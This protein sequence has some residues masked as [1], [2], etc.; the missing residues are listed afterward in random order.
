MDT[1]MARLLSAFARRVEERC[2]P[3]AGDIEF[4]EISRGN[5]LNKL[6]KLERMRLLGLLAL[7]AYYRD[8]DNAFVESLER[9]A[10]ITTEAKEL[11]TGLD[12]LLVGGIASPL[13][14]SHV[15]KYRDLQ[16]GLSAFAIQVGELLDLSGKPGHK[17]KSLS[18]TFLVAASEL[19]KLKTGTY[20]DEHLAELFQATGGIDGSKDFSGD[21]IRKKRDYL[22]TNYPN[23]FSSASEIANGICSQRDWMDEER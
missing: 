15:N 13:P 10:N 11:A 17:K 20:N 19:V 21:A 4:A 2:G 9:A 23:L 16:S 8:T 12:W 14:E 22:Q 6:T 7:Y 5:P 3:N 1:S 18:N